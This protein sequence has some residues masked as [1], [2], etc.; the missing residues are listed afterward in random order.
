MKTYFCEMRGTD[1]A[2]SWASVI[3]LWLH[4]RSRK[5]AQPCSHAHVPVFTLGLLALVWQEQRVEE[6][7]DGALGGRSGYA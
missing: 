6:G 3:V 4:W 1:T 5:F 7:L 2:G